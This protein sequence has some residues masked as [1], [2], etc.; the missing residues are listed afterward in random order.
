MNIASC[1]SCKHRKEDE[2][3]RFPPQVS[4]VMIPN[5]TALSG[6]QLQ[7]SPVAAFPNI[8]DDSYCGE[9]SVKFSMVA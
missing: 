2:C 1:S 9:Y 7:P 3:R 8:A 4:V 5:Q 6:M